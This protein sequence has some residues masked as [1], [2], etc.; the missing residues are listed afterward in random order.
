MEYSENLG[1]YFNNLINIFQP[2]SLLK[3]LKLNQTSK[4]KQW[5]VHCDAENPDKLYCYA[6]RKNPIKAD[7][8]LGQRSLFEVYLMITKLDFYDLNYT[9]Y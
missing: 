6:I 5:Y 8:T 2:S 7:G 1:I 3:L 9:D 4:Q